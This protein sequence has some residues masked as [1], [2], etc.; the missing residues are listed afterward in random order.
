MFKRFKTI[1]NKMKKYDKR[2]TNP[3]LNIKRAYNSE[4]SMY[5]QTYIWVE[6]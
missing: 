6:K 3:F 1:L 2:A 5:E 4:K